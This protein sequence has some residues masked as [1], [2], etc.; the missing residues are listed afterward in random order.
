LIALNEKGIP[1]TPIEAAEKNARGDWA[2]PT[3][4]AAK[5]AWFTALNPEGKVS[6]MEQRERERGTGD[7]TEERKR[8]ERER[9]TIHPF[10]P[11]LS[12]AFSLSLSLSFQVPT[13]LYRSEGAEGALTHVI[14]ESL[15]C[16]EFLEDFAPKSAPSLLPPH[17]AGR[18]L[19]RLAAKRVD[20]AL[21]PPFYR[22]M[23]GNQTAEADKADKAAL[24]AAIDWLEAHADPQGPFYCGAH[25]STADCAAIPFFLRLFELKA[26]TGFELPARCTRL[27]RWYGACADR[28]SVVATLAS[29]EEDMDWEDA[30]AKF[31]AH[32]LGPRPAGSG[33]A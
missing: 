6:D 10:T 29:P 25:F 14:P 9:G 20:D 16:L 21:V 8:G 22:L 26:R 32:Y 13:I 1:Y 11:S 31:F 17:P 28:D 30:L 33:A 19:A 2:I 3:D 24:L 15:I 23:R 18:A 4:R 7:G 12:F 27:I 5:P